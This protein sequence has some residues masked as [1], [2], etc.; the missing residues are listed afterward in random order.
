M[1]DTKRFTAKPTGG[2]IAGIKTRLANEC[3]SPIP[4]DADMLKRAIEAGQT[5]SPAIIDPMKNGSGAPSHCA[6]GFVQQQL[7]GIDLDN[8]YL[9]EGKRAKKDKQRLPDGEYIPHEKALELCEAAGIKPLIIYQTFSSTE[10][11]EKYRILFALDDVVTD[12]AER[13][14]IDRAAFDIFGR[15]TDQSCKN[16]DRIFYGSKPGS[17]VYIEPDAVTQ[18]SALL[19]IADQLDQNEQSGEQLPPIPEYDAVKIENEYKQSYNGSRWD[20]GS[21]PTRLLYMVN[22][23]ALQYSDWMRLAAAYKNS[24]GDESNFYAWC[25]Q[26]SGDKPKDDRTLWESVGKAGNKGEC[27]RGTLVLYAKRLN[28]AGFD[29]YFEEVTGHRPGEHPKRKQPAAQIE[30]GS[31]DQL[32]SG[33]HVIRYTD[34]SSITVPV[35]VVPTKTGGLVVSPSLMEETIRSKHRFIY[36]RDIEIS[37]KACY[38]Y[39]PDKGRYILQDEASLMGMCKRMVDDY[40][41]AADRAHRLDGYTKKLHEVVELLLTLDAAATLRPDQ[42]DAHEGK[43]NCKSGMID[44]KTGETL[45]HS[46][47]WCS[48]VQ[49]PVDYDPKKQYS[50]DDAPTFAKYLDDLTAGDADRKQLL[51]E[52]AGAV[53]SNVDGSRYKSILYLV[54]EGDTGKSQYVRLIAEILGNFAAPT[55]FNT[56]DDRFQ[57]AVLVG[58]RF[59]F[60]ADYNASQVSSNKTIMNVT[61]GD[62]IS[63]ERKGKEPFSYRYRGLLC[64]CSNGT[65]RMRGN[66]HDAFYNRLLICQCP[67][68]VPKDKQD[69]RLLHNMLKERETIVGVCL[70]AFLETVHDGRNY[71]FTVPQDNADFIKEMKAYNDPVSEF[72]QDYCKPYDPKTCSKDERF[73]R[74]TFYLVFKT[75]YEKYFPH[76]PIATAPQF[77]KKIREFFSLD[78]DYHATNGKRYS[79]VT[80]TQDARNELRPGS[81]SIVVSGI[82]W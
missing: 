9:P 59:C 10:A 81:E 72:L 40:N 28:P 31:G 49:L 67:N 71:S 8:D 15:A 16:A 38:A 42:M 58:R 55:N 43:I 65:P 47:K 29:S 37:G 46:P 60:D 2:A 13:Q 79:L 63:I 25:S 23:N 54:G 76:K 24:G 51:L 45:P 21:D 61:G 50:L 53:F 17:V 19:A 73:E 18:K 22:P 34:G 26:Y 57:N 20:S 36:T 52:Y 74:D 35:W 77:Y 75:W 3:S 4:T 5:I 80:L 11:L 64:V 82:D 32:D 39:F 27:K 68:P 14:R 30:D 44:M 69:K 7:F 6:D 48:T 62:N 56:L 33:T 70:A 1:I 12:D 66:L 78:K 41:R